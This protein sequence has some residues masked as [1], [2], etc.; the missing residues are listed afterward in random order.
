MENGKDAP[1]SSYA[2]DLMEQ[3]GRRSVRYT[4]IAGL[5]A[6]GILVFWRVT[7]DVTWREF[8]A[9]KT[10]WAL[11]GFCVVDLLVWFIRNRRA[12]ETERQILAENAHDDALCKQI[13]TTVN[14]F[15][16]QPKWRVA[17][18]ESV[19]G[20]LVPVRFELEVRSQF[21]GH[22]IGGYMRF[23]RFRV[24]SDG[25]VRPKSTDVFV[26]DKQEDYP[27]DRFGALLLRGVHGEMIWALIPSFDET[28][29]VFRR[30]LEAA[31]NNVHA[32]THAWMG[33]RCVDRVK[34]GRDFAARSRQGYRRVLEW[35]LLE[36]ER[37]VDSR[38]SVI[39]SGFE[40]KTN[41]ILATSIILDGEENILLP[42]GT[43]DDF[44]EMLT[45]L[46]SQRIELEHSEPVDPDTTSLRPCPA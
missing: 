16:E 8:I 10:A 13:E 12:W 6:F 20:S 7:A 39:L 36:I 28:E 31:M 42:T 2:R 37:P 33:L 19:K 41:I 24:G 45:K 46:L 43:L 40:L 32:G 26:P 30:I 22:F 14:D 25:S 23:L 27:L 29:N 21:L 1:L 44:A 35:L 34:L 11:V 18:R 17:T 15:V 4:L 3:S 38:S 5:C 9:F